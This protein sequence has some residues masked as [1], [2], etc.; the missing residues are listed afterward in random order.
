MKAY[1]QIIGYLLLTIIAGCSGIKVSQDYDSAANYSG[2]KT[3]NWQTEIQ[4][5]TGNVRL[6]NPLL[7]TRIRN[8]VEGY[9]SAKGYRKESEGRQNF[10]IS[11]QTT[12]QRKIVSD[13]TS[14]GVGVGRGSRGGSRGGV[15]MSSGGGVSQKDEGSLIIDFTDAETGKLI[16]RGS[17]SSRIYEHST[18]EKTTQLINAMVA[19]IL[20]Q[21]PPLPKK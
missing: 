15:S 7:D 3:Y 4:K 6:D 21:F 14:F 10:T 9:L 18:P 8:A 5:K 17:G 16:W 1:R 2:L 11:Y 12:I 19:K 20:D 13:N